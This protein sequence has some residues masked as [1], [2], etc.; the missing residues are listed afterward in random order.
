MAEAFYLP[1]NAFDRFFEEPKSGMQH[2][3]KI[4]KYPEVT[5]NTSRQGVGPH[6]DS[7][8]LTFLLQASPHAGLQVQNFAGTWVDAPP[9][10][11]AL[12]VNLGKGIETVTQG[13]ALATS[14]RV[15]SPLR[16]SGP[17]YSVPFFQMIGQEVRL[18]ESVLK[19]PAKIMELKNARGQ[20]GLTESVNFSEYGSEQAGHVQ[21]I[22]RIKSHPDV[23]ERHYPKLTKQIFPH[24]IPGKGSAY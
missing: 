15:L 7:G 8:F 23:G 17:R 21:L 10:P 11:N 16:G 1:P 19:M 22:G 3:C 14:H 9:M 13:V 24:G 6:F 2:R 5:G 18:G 12:V 20:G 4:V